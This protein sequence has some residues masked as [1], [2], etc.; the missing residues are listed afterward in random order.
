MVDFPERLKE[1]RKT[2]GVTQ[3]YMADLLTLKSDRTYRQYEA[4]EVDPPSS[5]AMRLADYFEVSLDYLFGRSNDPK[6][7]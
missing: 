3:K 7:Y 6:R 4:G 1:L 5:K 2:K